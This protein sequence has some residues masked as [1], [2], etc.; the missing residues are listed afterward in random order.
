VSTLSNH[1]A[2]GESPIRRYWLSTSRLCFGVWTVHG[3]SLATLLWGDPQ[4]SRLIGGPFSDEQ[5]RERLGREIESMELYKVQYWPIFGLNDGE[6]TGCAGLRPHKLDEKVYELGF[7]L[8]PRFWRK[9]LAFEAGAAV[10][11]F[12]FTQLGVAALFAG[13][14]PE[15]LA[16]KR[17]LGKLGF[18]YVGDQIYEPTGMM[19]PSYLLRRSSARSDA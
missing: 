7:H 14:H 3:L 11:Q 18:H 1:L 9:G 12:A 10:I 19:H 4:V 13:H 17:V 8:L 2:T 15:N 16:S 6:F 5:V